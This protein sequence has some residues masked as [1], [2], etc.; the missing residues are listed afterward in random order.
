MSEIYQRGPVTAG[1]QIFADF[2]DFNFKSGQVYR[3]NKQI[4]ISVHAVRIC[5]WVLKRMGL[6]FGG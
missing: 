4:R 5:G 2:Y 6:N 3:S 1:M